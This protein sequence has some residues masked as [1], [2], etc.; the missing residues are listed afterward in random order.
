M[1]SAVS[2]APPTPPAARAGLRDWL[3]D[4]GAVVLSGVRLWVRRWPVLLLIALLAVAGRYAAGW[5]A[6]NASSVNNTLGWMVLVLAPLSMVAGIVAMLHVLRRDLP[7]LAQ[8]GRT[9]G[10]PDATSGHERGLVDVLAS[11]FVPFLALYASYG[12]LA[13]DQMRFINTATYRELVEK[14]HVPRDLDVKALTQDWRLDLAAVVIAVILRWLLGRWEGRSHR[15]ALGFAGAYVEAFWLL[16]VASYATGLLDFVWRWIE[17]RRA[18]AIV[19]DWWLR[20]LD[21]IGPFAAPLDRVV[22]TVAGVLGNLDDLVVIPLAWLTVGAVVY[23]HKLAAL[24]K[25]RTLAPAAWR[26]VPAP[27]RRWTTEATAP[28]VGDVRG[29]FTALVD[30]LR[31]LAVAGLGPMLVFA[32]AFVLAT[33]AEEGIQLLARAVSGPQDRDTWLAFAPAVSALATAVALT[34]TMALLAAGVERILAGQAAMAPVHG[35]PQ[36]T[37]V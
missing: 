33:R 34:I 8:I 20:L 15:R 6:V 1:M 4:L 26:R 12:F 14:F 22:D 31:R 17:G 11:V 24:P 30:G 35:E 19:L 10:P 7:L 16:I 21:A 29:R 36:E 28:V 18:V 37:A 9:T 3:R 23:G 25:R 5:G 13:E 27:V 2:D 32:L